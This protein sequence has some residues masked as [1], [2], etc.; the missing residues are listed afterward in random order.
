MDTSEKN[1]ELSIVA[2][3]IGGAVVDII[4]GGEVAEL[5]PIY[6]RLRDE[7]GLRQALNPEINPSEENRRLAFADY[8]DEILEDM[9]ESNTDMY[10]KIVEDENFGDFFRIVMMRKVTEGF[11]SSHPTL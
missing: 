4:V 11:A 5:S 2:E 10:K 6:R 8:F 1:F 3:L 9:M 7:E